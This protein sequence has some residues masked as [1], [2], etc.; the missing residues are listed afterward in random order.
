MVV[1]ITFVT[2]TNKSFIENP[3]CTY[4][5]SFFFYFFFFSQVLLQGIGL[6]IC[7]KER[8]RE[9]FCVC[10]ILIYKINATDLKDW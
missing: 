10:W 1:R 3:I 7:E 4:S 5:V 6:N 8:E 2:L 9:K